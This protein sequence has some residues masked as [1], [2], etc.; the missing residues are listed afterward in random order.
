MKP[1]PFEKLTYVD[2]ASKV[3]LVSKPENGMARG[4]TEVFDKKGKKLWSM[5]SIVGRHHLHLS[6]DGSM[7]MLTGNFYFGSQ[8][9]LTPEENVATVYE[10]GKEVKKLTFADVAKVDPEA[11]ATERKLPVK[12]GGWADLTD[13]VTAVDVDWAKRTVT[14]KLFDGTAVDRTF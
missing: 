1:A 8:F 4:T 12:G 14:V 2:P 7:L 10:L 6:P 11:S 5:P 13:F 3:R 9:R